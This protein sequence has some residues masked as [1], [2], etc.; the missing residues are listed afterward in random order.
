VLAAQQQ[1]GGSHSWSSSVWKWVIVLSLMPGVT[2]Y[3]LWPFRLEFLTVRSTLERLA[4]QVAAGQA[5]S[6]PRSAGPFQLVASAV[7]SEAGGVALLID[8]NP[9]GPSGFVRHKNYTKGPYD[10]FRPIRGDW[11]HMELGGGWC[12]HEED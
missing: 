11:W 9:S 3:T 6:S 8:P 10:C 7:D 12:Y 1:M 5:V 4:D 2:A